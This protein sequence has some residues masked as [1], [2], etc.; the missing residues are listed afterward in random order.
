MELS[1]RSQELLQ[2][3]VKNCQNKQ[4]IGD[5]LLEEVDLGTVVSW[6]STPVDKNIA[7]K[8]ELTTASLC[9]ALLKDI[10][11]SLPVDVAYKL[12]FE[13]KN[14]Q[15]SKSTF[16]LLVLAGVIVVAC[17][18]FDGIT[19]ILG[20]WTLPSL[21]VFLAGLAFS[22][23]S[24]VIFC[25][26]DLIQVSKHLGVNLFD[27]PKL[28]DVYASQLSEIKLIRRKI[29]TYCLANLSAQKLTELENLLILLQLRLGILHKASKQFDLAL[30]STST[31]IVKY[32]FSGMS[33]MLFFAGGFFAGQ[34]VAA[35]IFGVLVTSVPSFWPILI[36]SSFV[37]LA[38]LVVYWYM[39]RPELEKLISNWFGLNEDK[40]EQL[41]D[42]D[43][44][45]KEE[46]KLTV[47]QD[48]IKGVAQ[49]KLKSQSPTDK[50]S[51]NP[52]GFYQPKSVEENEAESEDF[53]LSYAS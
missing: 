41:C 11:L 44:I 16:I 10:A 38:A 33:S 20:I 19:T 1:K 42:T 8:S 13:E 53:A 26:F 5:L 34:S 23:L 46:T 52:F 40:I 15:G 7:A 32:I 45:N 28:I 47:L 4:E 17:E 25:T 9:A 2:E 36:I 14:E 27:G 3:Y 37:G 43:K 30:N 22:L 24:I 51:R 21:V 49:L 18:G 31:Q 48:N 12:E 50:V 35:F 29:E 39:E 6:L